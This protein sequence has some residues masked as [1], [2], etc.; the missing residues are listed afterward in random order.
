[1]T[2]TFSPAQ[3]VAEAITVTAAPV[4]VSLAVRRRS[5]EVHPT[6][7]LQVGKHPGQPTVAASDCPTTNGRLF[8]IDRKTKIQYLVD[9]GSD[10]CVVPHTMANHLHTPTRNSVYAANGTAIPT[11]GFAHISLDFGLRREFSWRFVVATN[12]RR[13]FSLPFQSI[14]RLSPPT[15][16]RRNNHARHQRWSQDCIID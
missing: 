6:M 7:Q 1:M 3:F 15:P 4:L 11:Y 16:R 9:T 5:Q 8:A 12:N 2:I 10:L 14:G 13:R